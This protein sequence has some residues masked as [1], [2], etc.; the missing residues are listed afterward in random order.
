MI[1]VDIW[2][3]VDCPFCYIGKKHFELAVKQAGLENQI[4]KEWRSFQLDP[5]APQQYDRNIYQILA[6]KYDQ[7][8]ERAKDMSMNVVM[9][10][11][12]VGLDFNMDALQPTNTF[13]AHRLIHYAKSVGKQ[14][15][16]KE[17]LF[18]A[19][20]VQGEHIGNSKT[21]IQLSEKAGLDKGEAFRVLDSDQYAEDVQEDI[22]AA[23]TIGIQG[24]PFFLINKKYGISGAQPVASFIKVFEQIMGK[25]KTASV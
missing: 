17:M 21:L 24:V 22:K 23:Q 1:T 16:M 14:D 12:N 7:T 3:D 18:K 9:M 19:Y 4:K 15:E 25:E 11:A 20:F 2:S 10:A 5:K 13:D 6:S 8:E